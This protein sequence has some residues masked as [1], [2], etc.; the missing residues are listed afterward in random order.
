MTVGQL[1]SRMSASEYDEHRA[2]HSMEPF[3]DDRIA[4]QLAWLATVLA[5]T[6]FGTE[7]KPKPFKF[8]DFLL[9]LDLPEYQQSGESKQSELPEQSEEEIADAFENLASLFSWTAA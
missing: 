8:H 1:E 7:D 2:H 4:L 3:G 6:R 5:N 9:P